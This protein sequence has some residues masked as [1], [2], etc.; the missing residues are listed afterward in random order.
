MKKSKADIKKAVLAANTFKC[1]T[2]NC[3]HGGKLSLWPPFNPKEQ[4]E[5]AFI[6]TLGED[7]LI[8]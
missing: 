8:E 2:K 4:D 5:D 1:T 7:Q 3:K 6:M